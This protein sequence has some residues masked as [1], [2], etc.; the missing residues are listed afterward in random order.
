MTTILFK[1]VNESI[2]KTKII[3]NINDN[4]NIHK[5]LCFSVALI[6]L[7]FGRFKLHREICRGTFA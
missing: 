1:C 4:I 5:A 7:A 3:V 2:L 6:K